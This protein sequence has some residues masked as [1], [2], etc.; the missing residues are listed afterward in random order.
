MGI[1]RPMPNARL[2]TFSPGAACSRLYIEIDPALHPAHCFLIKTARDD[3]ARAEVF[4]HIKLQD[5]I[6]NLYGGSVS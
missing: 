4:L 3:V 1:L 6:E 2:V 5:F